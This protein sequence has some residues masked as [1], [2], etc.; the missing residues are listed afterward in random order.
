MRVCDYAYL[1][2]RRIA[3]RGETEEQGILNASAYRELED[4]ERDREIEKV[5]SGGGFTDFLGG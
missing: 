4:E 5:R 1:E 3:N 2:L